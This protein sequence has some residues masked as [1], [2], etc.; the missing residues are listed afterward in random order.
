MVKFTPG[1]RLDR[2]F[3]KKG[4]LRFDRKQHRP[5][6]GDPT[7]LAI[8]VDGSVYLVRQTR[9]GEILIFKRH[10]DGS[11][12]RKYGFGGF[13]YLSSKAGRTYVRDVAIGKDGKL[14][15]VG[16]LVYKCGRDL[17]CERKLAVYRL[18]RDGKPDPTWS[19]G[20]VTGG[21]G[22]ETIGTALVLDGQKTL[23]GGTAE[24]SGGRED[25][26]LVRYTG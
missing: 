5:W 17:D 7:L 18:R 3:G 9:G 11:R 15:L 20:L 16:Q 13:L 2:S 14:N 24:S 12:A 8:G 25:F 26:L 21:A 22:E 4:E 1:G 19:K 6:A 23:V 10:R